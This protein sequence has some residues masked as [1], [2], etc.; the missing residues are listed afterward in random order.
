MSSL[1]KPQLFTEGEP[2]SPHNTLYG[3]S[4]IYS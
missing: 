4:D 1:F 2:K 3:D